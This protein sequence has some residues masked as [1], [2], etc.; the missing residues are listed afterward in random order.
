[1]GKKGG[2]MKLK[3][4]LLLF[5]LLALTGCQENESISLESYGDVYL[6]LFTPVSAE[7]SSSIM[8]E[9]ARMISFDAFQT[10]Y[11]HEDFIHYYKALIESLDH[12]LYKLDQIGPTVA[13]SQI[14]YYQSKLEYSLFALMDTLKT[15]ESKETFNILWPS[16]F[17]LYDDM[18]TL[19]ADIDPLIEDIWRYQTAIESHLVKSHYEIPEKYIQ[20]KME[21]LFSYMYF[22]A[23]IAAH[24]S[25]YQDYSGLQ[26]DPHM[27]TRI[28]SS[29]GSWYAVYEMAYKVMLIHNKQ[30]RNQ[31]EAINAYAEALALDLDPYQQHINFMNSYLSTY[32]EYVSIR[33]MYPYTFFKTGDFKS[34]QVRSGIVPGFNRWDPD[35]LL[36][37]FDPLYEDEY[38]FITLKEDCLKLLNLI[39]SDKHQEYM[40]IRSK[41]E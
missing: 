18:Y 37:D 23:V 40:F 20:N 33:A 7:S 1:M 25:A 39:H 35:E 19:M 11:S 3:C 36:F 2:Y 14:R 6:E 12:I 24:V 22:D 34:Y 9:A 38:H 41:E 13:D 21:S 30:L 29:K 17:T 10:D 27:P 15:Y 4:I 5:M 26:L 28:Q 31:L 8:S 32:D 16:Q